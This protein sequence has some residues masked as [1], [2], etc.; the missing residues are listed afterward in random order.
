MSKWPGLWLMV[1]FLCT[2][3]AYG[4][5]Q[6]HDLDGQESHTS[7]LKR[8]MSV[9]KVVKFGEE[10]LDT[11]AQFDGGFR[12]WLKQ[13]LDLNAN[14]LSIEQIFYWW[15]FSVN[16]QVSDAV[17]DKVP[18]KKDKPKRQTMLDGRDVFVAHCMSCHLAKDQEAP[19]LA[20]RQAWAWRL[21]S[22]M[23]F[24]VKAVI[25]GKPYTDSDHPVNN[26][27]RYKI[28]G[29]QTVGDDEAQARV[30]GCELPRGGCKKCTDAQ[31]I[32]AVKY[33]AQSA[34]D[35]DSNYSLW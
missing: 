18:A 6:T 30:R 31:L 21:D 22:S 32:A 23:D 10:V 25:A 1:V 4:S 33:M 28:D 24:L 14:L 27:D 19:Q 11:G 34:S 26:Q 15:P 8:M 3:S 29:V 16:P 12:T 9:E 35:N 17:V 13:S 5:D 2:A 7:V 20:D